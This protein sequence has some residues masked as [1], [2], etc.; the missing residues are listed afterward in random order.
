MNKIVLAKY[1]APGSKVLSGRPEGELARKELKLNE[2]DINSEVYYFII[3]N[4]LRT[5]GTSFFL[6]LLSQSIKDLGRDAFNKKYKFVTENMTD[7]DEYV[8][9][10]I[11]E[12]IRWAE[13]ESRIL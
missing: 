8:Q 11:E 4:N 12:G 7:I 9:D 1:L 10:D 13:N 5:F 2:L 6:G 3:P